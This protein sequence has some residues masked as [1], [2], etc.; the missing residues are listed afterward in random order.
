MD[1]GL[2]SKRVLAGLGL[3]FAL[4]SSG[5]TAASATM[6][7]AVIGQ[8]R[9]YVFTHF[10]FSAPPT[11][12]A[13]DC[14]NG[15][16]M[17]LRDAFIAQLPPRD[18][19]QARAVK[20]FGPVGS[21]ILA[22]DDPRSGLKLGDSEEAMAKLSEHD[23]EAM[24]AK[25]RDPNRH[26]ICN[27][28]ADYQGVGFQTIDHG[29]PAQ[30]LDLD[31]T[32]DGHATARTCAHTKFAD[33]DG[34][35]PV[36][37]QYW[38]AF[39]CLAV[40]RHEG[41]AW[42]STIATGDWAVL[43]EVTPTGPAGAVDVNLYASKDSVTLDASGKIPAGLSL[44]YIDDPELITRT[45]GRIENGVLTT[46]P[47]NFTYK[48]DNQIVHNRPSFEAARFRLKLMPDGSLSG[49]MGAY[50]DVDKLYGFTIKP[51][52]IDGAS[53]NNIDCPGL[54][55]AM[56]S[57]ADGDRDAKSGACSALSVAFDVEAVPAFVIHPQG[58]AAADPGKDAEAN[59]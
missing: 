35:A 30:G 9:G 19:A 50:A 40:Y 10:R 13:K 36:D 24:I 53:A 49:H 4:M 39:G 17:S 59:P 12:L 20:G 52:T 22:T 51:Q 58:T 7:L 45:H 47:V 33:M 3:L 23:H 43:M 25:R 28:P 6:P 37:N 57:L 8:T 55:A 32:T 27:N 15:Y 26:T 44:D 29:G 2:S 34:V 31:G 18:Q 21:M 46:E 14:P 5:A 48:Y 54:Y 11:E 41:L 42:D 38:R 1:T 16:A 56:R